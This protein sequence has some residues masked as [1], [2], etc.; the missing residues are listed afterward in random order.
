MYHRIRPAAGYSVAEGALI[1]DVIPGGSVK[2]DR[3]MAAVLESQHHSSTEE[4]G[5]AGD[6]DR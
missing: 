1:C 3:L 4:P 6:E 2:A 5:A